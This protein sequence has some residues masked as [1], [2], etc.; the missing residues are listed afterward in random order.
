MTA[1]P[2][3]F[4][5]RACA[6]KTSSPSFRE[7]E[8]TMP[9]PCTHFSPAVI[10]SHL[11]ESIM[12]GTREISGSEASKFRNVTISCRASRRPSSM[13]TSM[14]I[15]PSSTCLRAMSNASSYFFSFISLRNLREPA[16]LQRSP[17][18]T[19]LISGVCSNSSSPLRHNVTGLSAGTCGC[20][21]AAKAWKRAMYSSVVPQQPPIMFT[22]PLST[23]NF[24]SS[25]ICPGV[26]S[27]CPKLLGSPAF[28]YT[29]I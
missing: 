2:R 4:T 11:E 10:T 5:S 9:L 14:T 21:C 12:T 3:R 7:M 15:A 13:F 20:P 22:H 27:Y 23:K 24:I 8:L 19:N 1:A 26:W 18:F 6:K 28:G 16:T 29:D 25:A 17:T